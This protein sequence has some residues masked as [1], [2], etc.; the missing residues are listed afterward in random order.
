MQISC[1]YAA[2]FAMHIR[3]LVSPPLTRPCSHKHECITGGK[4]PARNLAISAPAHARGGAGDYASV[5]AHGG[6]RGGAAGGAGGQL[7]QMLQSQQHASLEVADQRV[8]AHALSQLD[9]SRPLMQRL[10]VL[11]ELSDLVRA[12]KFA[13]LPALWAQVQDLLDDGQPSD[14]CDKVVNFIGALCTADNFNRLGILRQQFFHLVQEEAGVL[15][16]RRQLQVLSFMAQDCHNAGP[17]ERPVARLLSWW[18]WELAQGQLASASAVGD[19]V[20]ADQ[21][22]ADEL[23]HL[24]SMVGNLVK[25]SS[26][27]LAREDADDLVEAL[28]ALCKASCAAFRANAH[29]AAGDGGGEARGRDREAVRRVCLGGSLTVLD[30]VACYSIMHVASVRCVVETLCLAVNEAS[31]TKDAGHIMRHL[32]VGAQSLT[33]FN[34]LL[35]L[36]NCASLPPTLSSLAAAQAEAVTLS[37]QEASRARLTQV[38][39]LLVAITVCTHANAHARTRTR[40]HAHARAREHAHTHTGSQT[41]SLARTHAH[42]H[43]HVHVHV[44]TRT[45]AP[46]ASDRDHLP[47]EHGDVG[48]VARGEHCALLFAA[49]MLT[50]IGLFCHGHKPLLPWT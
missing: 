27:A 5:G 13:D 47:R 40:T 2:S 33:A 20:R 38:R 22:D 17:F 16:R 43:V 29:E 26:V 45:G 42:L 32:L 6:A 50:R 15:G 7:H 25:I 21:L 35:L 49:G 12:H 23:K 3:P 11:D 37:S 44:H 8:F 39:V 36:L 30:I 18:L 34:H 1:L 14:A 31:A 41:R 19:V 48:L 9:Q 46:L 10:E 28:C 24:L 4:W